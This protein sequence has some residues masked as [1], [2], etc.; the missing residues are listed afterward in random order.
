MSGAPISF[1]WLSSFKSTCEDSTICKVTT[2]WVVTHKD[3][4]QVPF[5]LPFRI[6]VLAYL[7][8]FYG[9]YFI[10]QI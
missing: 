6:P 2:F 5:I 1:T 7:I 8:N 4:L 10:L 9:T 3:L